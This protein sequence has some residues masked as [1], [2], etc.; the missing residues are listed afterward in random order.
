MKPCRIQASGPAD[1]V[2]APL[3]YRGGTGRRTRDPPNPATPPIVQPS[4]A[5]DEPAALR[6]TPGEAARSARSPESSAGPSAGRRRPAGECGRPPA[7]LRPGRHPASGARVAPHARGDRP[8]RDTSRNAGR[9]AHQ[10]RL[11]RCGQGGP[12]DDLRHPRRHTDPAV[13]HPYMTRLRFV[14]LTT[15][16]S[17]QLHACCF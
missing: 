5:S 17:A 2:P 14:R 8:A 3:G 9:G 12:R 6:R 1:L 11:Y 10:D 15:T 7:W 16:R 13:H 4:A